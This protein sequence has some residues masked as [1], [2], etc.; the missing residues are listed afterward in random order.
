MNGIACFDFPN[1]INR[2][3]EVISNC[4]AFL[5]IVGVIFLPFFPIFVPVVIGLSGIFLNGINSFQIQDSFR[6]QVFPTNTP[7]AN[8]DTLREDSFF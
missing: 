6:R 3:L 2:Y 5:A 7:Q 4:I 8:Y 1:P